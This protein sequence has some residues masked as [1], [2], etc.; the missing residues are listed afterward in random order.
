MT[1]EDVVQ[2]LDA[3]H[4]NPILLPTWIL[5]EDCIIIPI[6]LSDDVP[7]QVEVLCGDHFPAKIKLKKIK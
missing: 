4:S 7:V 1:A 6:A 2:K 5:P 3:H